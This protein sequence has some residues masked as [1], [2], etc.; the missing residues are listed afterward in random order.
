MFQRPRAPAIPLPR[1]AFILS[2]LLGVGL[3]A[4]GV[5][6]TGIDPPNDELYY[7]LSLAAHPDGRFLYVANAV[8]D[9]AYNAGTLSV[10]DTHTRRLVPEGSVRIGLFA[11]EMVV[12][13]PLDERCEGACPTVGYVTSR[14]DQALTFFE[15]ESR[16][17]DE[18]PAVRCGQGSSQTCG[19]AAHI[20][21][22]TSETKLSPSPYGLAMDGSGVSVTHVERGV[23]SRWGWRPPS[24]AE[25]VDQLPRSQLDFSCALTLATGASSVARH[26]VLGWSYVTDRMGSTILALRSRTRSERAQASL[27]LPE[28]ELRVGANLPVDA[29]GTRGTTRGIA[30][31]ADG[32]LMYV[33][34][35]TDRALRIYDTTVDERG[36][37]RNR[38]LQTIPLGYQ[39]N[40][41]RVA[42][43]RPGE[44]RAP[45]GLDHSGAAQRVIDEKGQGLVYVSVF[46][47][48]RVSV[49]DPS[50]QA[51]VARVRVG[52]GP[53]DIAFLPDADGQL[54]GYVSNFLDH[55]ISVLD[56]EPGSP[57]R[58]TRLSTVR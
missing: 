44:V 24:G 58:F 56:L 15:L 19:G 28:C 6:E 10:L 1:K 13:R 29:S 2:A 57:S 16:S 45:D 49:I 7:P 12:G 55:S 14:E 47:D 26:P 48:D 46:G 52:R 51:V 36:L 8:F 40:M 11:G 30:F 25:P 39:P 5:D 3:S 38:L 17:P 27:D 42:G 31:S 54:R 18:V 37:P 50:I 20:R 9:R 4:C 35:N 53:Q 32:T 22:F 33:A 41:V 34:V 21:R 23:L 43:L